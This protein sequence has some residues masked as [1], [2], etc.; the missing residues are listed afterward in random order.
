LNSHSVE[1][2]IVGGHAVAFHGYPRLTVD[3]DL[4]V[5]PSLD[6]ASKLL[7]ALR[8]F[9][10][11]AVGL[12]VGD[13]VSPGKIIQL[14]REPNRI[15]LLTGISGVTFEEAWAE[16][17][18]GTLDDLPAAFIGKESLL[19]NKRASARAKDLADVDHLERRNKQT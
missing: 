1:Y 6:N 14:G 11:G 4:F 9:G 12:N 8:D 2:L 16:R 18:D 17:V 15:D 10:F 5:R 3:I 19:R 7:A 13:F